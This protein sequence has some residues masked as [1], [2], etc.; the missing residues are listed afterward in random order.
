MFLPSFPGSTNSHRERESTRLDGKQSKWFSGS[1]QMN[2]CPDS[3]TWR[4][5]KNKWNV[6]CVTTSAGALDTAK[7]FSLALKRMKGRRKRVHKMVIP[8]G[9]PSTK[10]MQNKKNRR[11]NT[12]PSGVKFF[13]AFASCSLLLLRSA[14]RSYQNLLFWQQQIFHCEKR[15]SIISFTIC[16][17]YPMILLSLPL[18][19]SLSLAVPECTTK[20]NSHCRGSISHTHCSFYYALQPFMYVMNKNVI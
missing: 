2:T 8:T 4:K 19:S 16:N 12:N 20:S 1:K 14:A 18:A 7:E 15:S 6:F 9:Q 3:E 5:Q 13:M 10:A 17:T 11:R